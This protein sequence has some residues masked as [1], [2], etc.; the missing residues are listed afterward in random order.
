MTRYVSPLRYPGGKAKLAGFIKLLLTENELHDAHYVEP[1]AGGASVAL[2]L[3]VSEHV[4]HAHINDIDPGIH[5]FWHSVLFKTDD[6]CRR[7]RATP[8]TIAEWRR[9]R[10]VR[11]RGVRAGL[12]NLGFATLFLNRTN[13]SGI[14]NSGG[15]IGGIKQKGEWKIDARFGRDGLV[16]RIETIAAYRDRITLHNRDAADLLAD[17]LPELPERYFLYLDPPYY[18]KGQRRLYFNGYEHAD[19]VK[20]ATLMATRRR[21]MVSY[22]DVPA[23]R[24]IYRGFTAVRYQLSYSAADRISGEEIAFVSPDIQLPRLRKQTLSTEV[25]RVRSN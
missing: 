23:I 16:E 8:L 25:S 3:L 2:S 9:Q 20:I 22:D 15:P 6:L 12:L 19:H 14:I 1:Y 21:W 17:I 5:A 24:K 13:R 11:A 7:I 18:V 10:A 4:A